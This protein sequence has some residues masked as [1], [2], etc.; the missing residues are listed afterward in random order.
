[1]AYSW[2]RSFNAILVTSS[3]TAIAFLANAGSDIRPIRAFGIFAAIIIPVNFFIIITVIPA[4]QII[5]DKW[6]LPKGFCCHKLCCKGKATDD[7]E[8][9]NPKIDESSKKNLQDKDLEEPSNNP[10]QD[11]KDKPYTDPNLAKHDIIT[12]FMGGPLNN[13]DRRFRYIIVAVLSILGVAGIG[14]AT[15]IGPLTEPDEMLPADHPMMK[16]SKLIGD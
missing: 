12:R 13:F 11:K 9:R 3:T 5:H 2:K 10:N 8:K 1:M 14:V 6:L 7:A 16:T 4:A 15:Q